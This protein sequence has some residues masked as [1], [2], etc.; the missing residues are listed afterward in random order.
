MIAKQAPEVLR[1]KVA[2]QVRH[3]ERPSEVAQLRARD[4]EQVGGEIFNKTK[5]VDPSHLVHTKLSSM[6]TQ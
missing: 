5:P 2:G 1:M 4:K 6:S 3:F